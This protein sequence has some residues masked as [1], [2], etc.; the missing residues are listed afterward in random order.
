MPD[1]S[2]L[3]DRDDLAEHL[4]KC[5]ASGAGTYLSSHHIIIA[6]KELREYAARQDSVV[7]TSRRSLSINLRS[8]ACR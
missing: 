8:L 5:I 3:I 4:T 1:D 2:D 6:L 7:W